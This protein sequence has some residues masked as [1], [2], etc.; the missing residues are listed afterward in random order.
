M[1]RGSQRTLLAYID[2]AT[3]ELMHL[4]MVGG[5]SAFAYPRQKR[6]MLPPSDAALRSAQL[7]LLS[8]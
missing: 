7:R 6:W 5:E 1:V 3:S 4:K 2:D 8:C